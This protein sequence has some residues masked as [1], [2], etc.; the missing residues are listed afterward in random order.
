[1]VLSHSLLALAWVLYCILHSVLAAPGIKAWFRTRLGGAYRYYRLIYSLSALILL[2]GLLV[3]QRSIPSPKLWEPAWP[4][5]LPGI[6]LITLGTCGAMI[7]L[8][9]YFMSPQGIYD[10]FFE[11]SKP[12][13]QIRGLHQLVRHPLYLSSLLLLFGLMLFLP[14]LSFLIMVLLIWGYILAAIPFEEKKLVDL[15]GEDYER[16]RREV[17]ALFPR[18]G[19]MKS[20]EIKG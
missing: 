11:G 4:V 12:V 2:I 14:H 18:M 8:R 10:L 13:L 19:K 16:Y 17:P 1:M 5:W 9:N 3:W 7:S 15:Y 6:M 20:H